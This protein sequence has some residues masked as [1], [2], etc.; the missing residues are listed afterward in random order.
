M[1]ITF[2]FIGLFVRLFILQGKNGEQLQLKAVAQW[3]RTLPLTAKRG[4]IKDINGTVLASSYTSYSVYIRAKEVENAVEVAEY[5]S[6]KL[7]LKFETVYEPSGTCAR[8]RQKQSS[9]HTPQ[10]P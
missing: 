9:R 8:G 10:E 4:Q 6:N 2:C 1:L 5:L 3:V 7:N